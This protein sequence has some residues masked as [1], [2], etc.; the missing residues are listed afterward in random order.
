MTAT[1]NFATTVTANINALT[2]PIASGFI[3]AIRAVIPWSLD[4]A[5]GGIN[6]G[7]ATFPA[8]RYAYFRGHFTQAAAAPA[9]AMQTT[10][11]QSSGDIMQITSG[12]AGAIRYL[13]IAGELLCSGSGNLIFDAKAEV[14]NTTAKVMDGGYVIA[15]NVGARA[16]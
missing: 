10:G 8:A 3:Y 12:T 6:I 5:A 14:A 15:W 4:S 13:E 1:Q 2:V 7:I 11:R 16:I 9:L